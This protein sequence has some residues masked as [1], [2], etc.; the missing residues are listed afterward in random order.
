MMDQSARLG[1]VSSL[2]IPAFL[3][4]LCLLGGGAG[5]GAYADGITDIRGPIRTREMFVPYLELEKPGHNCDILLQSAINA[6]FESYP[7]PDISQ[8]PDSLGDSFVSLGQ[9]WSAEITYFPWGS[10]LTVGVYVEAVDMG[11]VIYRGAQYS[12]KPPGRSAIVYDSGSLYRTA[13]DEF[14]NAEGRSSIL[15]DTG[16][17]INLDD[18]YAQPRLVI[19]NNGIYLLEGYGRTELGPAPTL[20]LYPVS[21]EG[22]SEP[23]CIVRLVPDDVIEL[24]PVSF[25]KLLRTL[26]L[27]VGEPECCGNWSHNQFVLK[28]RIAALP[29]RALLRPWATTDK[30]FN[31]RATIDSC[32]RRF[33]SLS[34]LLTYQEIEMHLE[35]SRRELKEYYVASFRY[36]EDEAEILTEHILDY[37]HRSHFAFLRGCTPWRRDL[38][39]DYEWVGVYPQN[40]YSLVTPILRDATIENIEALLKDDN[41]NSELINIG[42]MHSLRRPDV[43]TLLLENGADPEFTNSYFG[44]TSLMFAAHLNIMDAVKILVGTGVDVNRRTTK[45]TRNPNNVFIFDRTALFYAT[46]NASLEMV[47]YLVENGADILAID[48]A[49]RNVFHYLALNEDI[50]GEEREAMRAY[51]TEQLSSR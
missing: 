20:T 48:S 45:V 47:R 18:D 5:A 51:L 46:E 36:R 14:V 17:H 43:L 27:I 42:L 35:A 3:A 34:L 33:D 24:G 32:D 38:P 44:K 28:R 19:T 2:L 21:R 11:V 41:I 13:I 39:D 9:T 37:V 40:Q 49:K 31:T 25:K 30:P 4:V 50:S 10:S 8:L 26:D 7:S 15:W 23:V 16:I 6:Y 22:K 12:A 29:D 1:R